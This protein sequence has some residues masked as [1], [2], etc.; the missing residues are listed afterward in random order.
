[1]WDTNPRSNKLQAVEV[2]VEYVFVDHAWVKINLKDNK[3]I[4]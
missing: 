1:M 2:N 3:I 4:E